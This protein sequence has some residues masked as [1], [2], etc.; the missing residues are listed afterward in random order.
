MRWLFIFFLLTPKAFAAFEV[1]STFLPSMAIIGRTDVVFV[2]HNTLLFGADNFKFG[3]Y[4][5]FDHI[6]ENVT[7]QTVGAA[8][9]FGQNQFL[10]LQGG[11]FVRKFTQHQTELEGTG[12]AANI[13][14]G[15]HINSAF[16]LSVALS[17]KRISSG[18]D[19]RTILT[20]LPLLSLR[21][22]Y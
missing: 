20:A 2:S 9:R 21:W 12:I 22:G 19:K 3:G 1:K 7:D 6:S 4:L 16:G 10:E 5:G 15:T 8:L 11:A 13:L 14:W 18:M 17:A